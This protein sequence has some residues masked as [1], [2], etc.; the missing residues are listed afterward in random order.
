MK[1]S[2]C[3]PATGLL[4]FAILASPAAFAASVMNQGTTVTT[5]LLADLPLYFVENQ[6]QMDGAVAFYIQ[7]KGQ[8]IYFTQ[9]GV[10]ISSTARPPVDR[11]SGDVL[12]AALSAT[13]SGPERWTTKIDFVGARKAPRITGERKT[14]AV[15]SYFR[16]PKSEWKAGLPTYASIRYSEVW[17]GIDVVYSGDG[18]KLKWNFY[19]QPGADPESIGLHYRGTELSLDQHGN[20]LMDTPLGSFI[21]EVPSAYQENTQEPVK[22][23]YGL[24]RT[25]TGHESRSA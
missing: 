18:S 12:P 19:I 15:F 23:A 21:D 13:P 17:P 7:G 8:T 20:L 3:L 4:L 5:N 14:P 25:S 6:G 1:E 9:S 11:L 24:G 2:K 10:T 22:V 16:G